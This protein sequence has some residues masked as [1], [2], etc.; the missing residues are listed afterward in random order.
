MPL[1]LLEGDL[2]KWRWCAETV[3]TLTFETGAS[4]RTRLT[5]LIKDKEVRSSELERE[6]CEEELSLL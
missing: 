6:L 5:S 2:E 4:W 1:E 3:E